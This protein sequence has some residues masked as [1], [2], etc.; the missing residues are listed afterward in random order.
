MSNSLAIASVTATLRRLLEKGGI[1]NVTVRPLDKAPE[2]INA[3]KQRINLFLYQ[4]LPNAAFRNMD[5]PGRVKSGETGHPPLPLTLYYLLTAYS[6]DERDETT[7][8]ALLGKA[9]SVFHDHPLLGTEEIKDAVRTPFPESDLAEQVERVRITLQPLLF[10][11]MSKLWT[12]FQIHYRLSAAYQVSVVLIESTRPTR[13]PLPVLTRQVMVQAN[14]TPPFPTLTEITISIP[15]SLE[16]LKALLDLPK[17][18]PGA[19]LG[20]ELLIKGHHLDGSSTVVHLMHPLLK[21][22]MEIPVEG[23][24]ANELR[25]T[26]PNKPADLPA[27]LYVLTARIAPTGQT[28]TGSERTTNA[29]SLS[30]TPTIKDV[31]PKTLKRDAVLTVECRPEVR[32]TQRVSVLL[33]DHELFPEARPAQTDTVKFRLKSIAPGNYFVRLRVDGADS[34]F[35]DWNRLDEDDA[36]IVDSI[37][38]KWRESNTP[39]VYDEINKM[40]WA[41]TVK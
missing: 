27:G 28:T 19:L 18:Q 29:L 25:V 3:D 17:Q 11:E 37:L 20:D 14:L 22:P 16:R 38:K 32:G 10:E 26:V 41:V 35:I 7:S 4:A 1:E 13:T 9:M 34:A 30:L 33:G 40:K 31:K 12:T 21:K 23:G 24:T 2:G 8:H 5:M 39:P 36:K 6:G 15:G